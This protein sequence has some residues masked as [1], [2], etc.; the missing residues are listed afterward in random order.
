MAFSAT[1]RVQDVTIYLLLSG[2]QFIVDGV[3]WYWLDGAQW[4]REDY[5]NEA[6]PWPATIAAG[7]PM[8]ILQEMYGGQGFLDD[9]G[10]AVTPSVENLL[11]V[12]TPIA[13]FDDLLKYDLVNPFDVDGLAKWRSARRA[14]A[15]FG[16]YGTVHAAEGGRP[17]RFELSA[18]VVAAPREGTD[19]RFNLALWH[20][21]VLVGSVPDRF[22]LTLD[23][24]VEDTITLDGLDSFGGVL[25]IAKWLNARKADPGAGAA[26]E[27]VGADFSALTSWNSRQ[28]AIGS[29]RFSI[30]QVNHSVEGDNVIRFQ[31]TGRV[32]AGTY[33]QTLMHDALSTYVQLSEDVSTEVDSGH[34]GTP[35]VASRLQIKDIVFHGIDGRPTIQYDSTLYVPIGS[36]GLLEYDDLADI[37]LTYGAGTYTR[38]VFRGKPGINEIHFNR[39]ED[40][41]G[42]YHTIKLGNPSD[43]NEDYGTV[44]PLRIASQPGSKPLNVWDWDNGEIIRLLGGESVSMRFVSDMEGQGRLLVDKFNRR[45]EAHSNTAFSLPG[46]NQ[47][48]YDFDTNHWARLVAVPTLDFNHAEV[49]V[50]THHTPSGGAWAGASNNARTV[51]IKRA[52][53]LRFS[54]S[55]EIRIDETHSGV[56]PAGSRI[57]TYFKRG[58]TFMLKNEDVIADGLSGGVKRLIQWYWEG[59]VEAD[60]ILFPIWIIG[61]VSGLNPS[62]IMVDIFNRRLALEVSVIKEYSSA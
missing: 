22:N 12:D 43:F 19:G 35:I 10:A 45:N 32:L 52:G 8:R 13:S 46:Q 61:K 16:D 25:A 50:S 33:T 40:L 39:T 60:D 30:V 18:G 34:R 21:S 36:W 55:I 41:Q 20:A 29:M 1:S 44:Y 27:D 26:Y 23:I 3:S 47:V 56:L 14:Q 4:Q 48:Y 5:D 7:Q 17:E 28:W 15:L 6:Y 57:A 31:L 49:F 38:K 9:N 11:D 54:Q 37:D 58:S 53:H 62:N 51:Q 42:L 24:D 2:G 59:D